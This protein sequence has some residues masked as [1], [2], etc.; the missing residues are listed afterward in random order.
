MMDN[1]WQYEYNKSIGKE[2]FVE[3]KKFQQESNRYQGDDLVYGKIDKTDFR[4]SE[5]SA[6][7]F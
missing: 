2:E 5:L 6:S 3:S 4:R 7:Y 1:S